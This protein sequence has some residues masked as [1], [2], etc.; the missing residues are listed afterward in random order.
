V[1]G[2]ALMFSP[3]VFAYLPALLMGYLF[4]SLLVTACAAIGI[5]LSGTLLSAFVVGGLTLFLPRF[6][7]T[8]LNIVIEAVSNTLLPTH[9]GPFDPTLNFPVS[10]IAQLIYQDPGADRFLSWQTPVYTL[11]LGVLFTFVGAFLFRRRSSELAEHAAP[12]RIGQHIVRSLI[13]LPLFYVVGYLL[14]TD[15][16]GGEFALIP[17]A[18]SLLV[19]FLYELIATRRFKNLLPALYTLPIAV[20]VVFCSVFGA[21]AYARAQVRNVPAADEI[22]LVSLDL[23]SAENYNNLRAAEV[24]LSNPQLS[25]ILCAALQRTADNL[26]SVPLLEST[27]YP[28]DDYLGTLSTPFKMTTTDGHTTRRSV[29]IPAKQINTVNA[30]M[31]RDPHFAE[32][33]LALPDESDVVFL[34]QAHMDAPLFN[35]DADRTIWALYR[36][37]YE[38]LT[39]EEKLASNKGGASAWRYADFN[40]ADNYYTPVPLVAVPT[41]EQ[42]SDDPFPWMEMDDGLYLDESLAVRGLYKLR[43]F[44]NIYTFGAGTPKTANLIMQ[45]QNESA[46]DAALTMR[47][48]VLRDDFTR[49]EVRVQLYNV[50]KNGELRHSYPRMLIYDADEV[51]ESEL[52]GQP[53]MSEAGLRTVQNSAAAA[54]SILTVARLL[55]AADGQN[56][57][58]DIHACFAKFYV[59]M[60]FRDA[61]GVMTFQTGSPRFAALTQ[62]QAEA[63]I[64]AMPAYDGAWG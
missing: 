29:G 41:T 2:F 3:A 33:A 26:D 36:E 35:A 18:L 52:D 32:A 49:I 16:T 15:Q 22:A 44:S 37:E 27:P 57:T 42:S 39:L 64:A 59:N 60:W 46:P 50:E 1:V 54:E 11:A 47:T 43:N 51:Y 55:T 61:S 28:M 25:E 53:R 63:I 56:G 9:L 23:T 5:G 30:L 17:V 38:T 34:S 8:M 6:I 4:G 14:Y 12:S 10:L 13:G 45:T 48:T 62:A 24:S 21:G 19:Y 58:P 40:L 31:M 7:C 20:A